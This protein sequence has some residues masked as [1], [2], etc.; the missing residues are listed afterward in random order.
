MD[1]RGSRPERSSQSNQAHGVVLV[2]SRG[3]R[4]IDNGRTVPEPGVPP[5]MP[6]RDHVERRRTEY[7]RILHL[8][9]STVE[10]RTSR[11]R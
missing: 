2:G 8:A 9:A 6:C 3:V 4:R 5:D 7:V 11:P 10:A 1:I